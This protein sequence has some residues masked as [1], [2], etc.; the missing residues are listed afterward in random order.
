MSSDIIYA[1]VISYQQIHEMAEKDTNNNNKI[2]WL[3][4]IQGWAILLVVIGHVNAFTYN[5][6]G[7]IYPLGNFIQTFCYSFHM[8]LFMFV[9][10][11]LLYFSRLSKGWA[12]GELYKDKLKR[13]LIP[14]IA[15]TIIGFC[16]KIPM[17]AFTKRGIDATPGGFI[18][19]LFDPANG[20]LN[21]LWFIGTLMWLM[22][23]YPLYKMMLKSAW[24]EV[25]LLTMTLIPFIID[26]HPKFNG[27]FNLRDVSQYAFFFVGGILFFKYNVIHY[28]E[29]SLLPAIIFTCIYALAWIIDAAPVCLATAGILMSFGWG[30]QVVRFFP[31]LFNLFRDYSFQIFLVGIF[32]Q[33]LVELVVWRQVHSQSLVVPFYL[34]SVLFALFAGVLIGKYGRRLPAILRW[35]IGLK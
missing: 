28:F 4:I 2:L 35:C 31:G 6:D 15:F 8:P 19:A 20:P 18:N 25:I 30:A 10:G 14:Y 17:S 9:S 13:L 3:S 11:G 1:N 22:L 33:M 23:M 16:I 34:V 5:A 29:R 24:T 32:P 12:T 21:E 27:W 26:V 7:E